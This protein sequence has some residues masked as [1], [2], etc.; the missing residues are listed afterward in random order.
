MRRIITLGTLVILCLASN[1]AAAW[2]FHSCESLNYI[3]HGTFHQTDA[4]M[5]FVDDTGVTFEIVNKGSWKDGM[6]G[7]IYAEIVG[8]G[9]CG[10]DYTVQICDWDADYSRNVVGTL[11]FLNFIECPGYYIRQAGQTTNLDYFI[12]NHEDFPALFRQENIGK[13]LKAELLVHTWVTNCIGKNV[14]EL[15]DYDFLPQQ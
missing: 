1:P 2:H 6:V 5:Q 3:T 7:T 11:V 13:K 15:I 10:F 8:P 4:C 9:E 12:R 14:S